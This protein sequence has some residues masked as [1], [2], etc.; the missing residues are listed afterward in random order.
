[1]GH[2][3]DQAECEALDCLYCYCGQAIESNLL[4]P[5]GWEG[6]RLSIVTLHYQAPAFDSYVREVTQECIQWCPDHAL[7]AHSV[8]VLHDWT[9]GLH[10]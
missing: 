4:E 3:L 6:R 5:L 9:P 1:M 2:V 7:P 10:L 8:I